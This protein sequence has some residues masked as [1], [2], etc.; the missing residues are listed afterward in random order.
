MPQPDRAQKRAKAKAG[1]GAG[2]GAAPSSTAAAAVSPPPSAAAFVGLHAGPSE[3][4]PVLDAG[5]VTNEEAWR[6]GRLLRVGGATYRV[7]LNPPFCD[8]LELHARPFV[9]IPLVPA[10]QVGAGCW[11]RAPRRQGDGTPRG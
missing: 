1:A 9:G 3:Q 4:H 7:E 5:N 6:H 10:A 11:G 2:A 8:R